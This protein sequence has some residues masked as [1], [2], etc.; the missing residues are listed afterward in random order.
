MRNKISF[1][2]SWAFSKSCTSLPMS[3]PTDW[4]ILDLPHT[5]NALD[6]QDGNSDYYRGACWYVK[7]FEKPFIAPGDRI[8]LEFEGAAAVADIYVNSSKVA[9]HEGSYSTF[10]AD[11]TDLLE[12]TGNLV[13]ACVDNSNRSY[14]YPQVADFTFYGGLYRDVNLLVVSDTHFELDYQGTE[15]VKVTSEIKGEDAL[16][17][18]DAWVSNAAESDSVQFLITDADEYPVAE[19]FVPASAH[20]STQLLLPDVHL[21]Q[22]VTDPYLY[23]VTARVIRANDAI[24]EVSVNLGVREYCVDPEKGFFLNG[25]SMP[26]RGVSR[27]QDRLGVG[28]ALYEEEHWEDAL[29][30]RELGANTVRLAHYQHNQAFYDACDALGLIVWAEIPFISVMNPDPM[31]HENCKSQMH[32][33]ILQ[34]YNHPSICFWGI[35]NEI[36]IGGEVPGL[37]ENLHDL[38][39]LVHR[40][41][42]TRMTTMA[43]VSMLSMDSPQNQITDVVSYN[44][45]FGW[46]GGTLDMNEKWLDDFHAKY[47]DRPLGISEYGAEGIITYHN[48][49]P[50]CR[51]YSE[52]YQAVYH[53]HMAKIIDE[54]PYLWATHVWNMFDFGCDAR[55]EGGVKGRNNKGLVS[56][57]RKTKKDA[58]YLYKAYWSDEPFVHIT[59][60]RYAKRT[61]DT[62]TI[63]V[64]SNLPSV[65]LFLDGKDMGT[66]TG[67]KVFLFEN[68]PFTP[69]FHTVIAKSDLFKDSA[70]FEKVSEPVD[71]YVLPASDDD[72]EGAPNWFD[73]VDISAA[74]AEMTFHPDFYS[75]NDTVGELIENPQIRTLLESAISTTIGMNIKANMLGMVAQRP[76]K[77]VTMLVNKEKAPAGL[78]ESLNA[79]LQKIKKVQ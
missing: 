39:E 12:E 46:Y 37:L 36:T 8:Y 47:P 72:G 14:I 20:V 66:Q 42:P 1:N 11:I 43:Q 26:L 18:L 16:I 21:W 65:T 58:Y 71:A 69:G 5:W 13:C 51:D 15:G 60:K 38:N 55:D 29:M 78:I 2:D 49:N 48:D 56:L 73:I 44:H 45:Y 32:E 77:D 68:L 30:I 22:G 75:I 6:G 63:K 41:D 64:Y 31:G 76:L 61:G 34:N 54:R 53:E 19:A 17:K 10:R 40:L 33:L 7:E 67:S 3:F 50:K 59:S 79:E 27:H 52:E 70:T 24:D 23:T 4:E 35:S 28:N 25:V 9:H 62:I 57:D 74:P